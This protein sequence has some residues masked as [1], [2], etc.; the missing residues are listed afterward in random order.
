[1]HVIALRVLVKRVLGSEGQIRRRR[2]AT[3]GQVR[4]TGRVVS[5]CGGNTNG[6]R[7]QVHACRGQRQQCLSSLFE[8][9]ATATPV[10]YDVRG[11]RRGLKIL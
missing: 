5:R 7:W 1:M 3:E 6:D 4:T 9:D 10:Q 2:K 8:L 11:R